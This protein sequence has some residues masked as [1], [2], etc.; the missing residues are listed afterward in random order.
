MMTSHLAVGKQPPNSWFW[1]AEDNQFYSY[2]FG[3]KT[4]VPQQLPDMR[5]SIGRDRRRSTNEPAVPLCQRKPSSWIW[6][7]WPWN[8]YEPESYLQTEYTPTAFLVSLYLASNLE[9]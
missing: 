1:A 5:K 9:H 2:I 6:K 4:G 8:D 7:Q 3:I